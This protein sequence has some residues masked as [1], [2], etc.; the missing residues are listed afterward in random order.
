MHE[1]HLP[2][3]FATTPRTSSTATRFAPHRDGGDDDRGGGGGDRSV[4]R[5]AQV[6]GT[7]ILIVEDEPA[8]LRLL[9][10]MLRSDGHTLLA[11]T[12][13]SQAQAL[14]D[15]HEGCVD[16]LITDLALPGMRGDVL[17]R[18]L[19]AQK[20]ELAVLFVSGHT[21]PGAQLADPGP[22]AR[23]AALPKPFSVRELL[24]VVGELL[25]SRRAR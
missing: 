23:T 6:E 2:D 22:A 19:R 3:R 12:N 11:A 1:P 14:F 8:L 9:V 20:P 21:R 16:L 5:T 7:H 13:A 10:R 17:A 18:N 25:A 24:G 15:E 4:G